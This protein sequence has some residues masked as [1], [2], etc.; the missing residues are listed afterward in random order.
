MIYKFFSNIEFLFSTIND[1]QL[2]FSKVEDFNDPFEWDFP[3]KINVDNNKAEIIKYVIENS[4]NRIPQ[5]IE[6]KINE[7]IST[8]K[9]LEDELNL[10]LSYRKN[11]GVCC[12][13]IPENN[14]SIL[15]WSHYANNHKRL[16]LAFSESEMNLI[17]IYDWV[18]R[19]HC[20]KAYINK[21][22]YPEDM[23]CYI[24]PFDKNRP[25]TK[26]ADFIKSPIW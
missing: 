3:Y 4:F 10:T 13:T 16:V 5:Y 15:M 22:T 11:K 26:D 12:F 20:T 17:H 9:K 18:N 8:P 14:N 21:V 23:P 25:T 6:Y 19:I 1:S 24:N 2:W 7:Y